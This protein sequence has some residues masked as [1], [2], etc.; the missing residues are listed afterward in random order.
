MTFPSQ[1]P[2]A[3]QSLPAILTL[4]AIHPIDFR[5]GTPEMKAIWEEDFRLRCLFKVEGAL[6]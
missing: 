2:K 3:H 4:M 1:G 6:A 5:Y